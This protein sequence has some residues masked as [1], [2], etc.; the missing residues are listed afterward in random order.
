MKAR[1][2]F[3][4]VAAGAVLPAWG[5]AQESRVRRIGFLGVLS[6]STPS[7][8]DVYYDA[9]VQGMRELGY[10]E[11]K[12]LAIEWRFAEGKFDRLPALAAELAGLKVEVIVT[13]STPAIRALQRAT[14]SIPVVFAVAIDPVASGFAASLAR[15]GGNIT[16]LSVIDVD[17]SP[18]RLELLKTMNPALSRAAVLVNPSVPAHAA[19]VKSMQAAG[20][21]AGINVVPV[22]A[23][24]A[25]EIEQ[26]FAVMLR[27]R[28]GGAVVS[29]DAFFRGQRR[30]IAALALRGRIPAIA[31]WREYVTAGGLMSYGQD[32]ADS[33]RRTA[34]YVDKILK[35]ARPGELAIEQPTRIHLA[36][37]RKTAGALGL[38]IPRELLLRADEAID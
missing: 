30:Q 20:Q 12:N 15:P 23:R 13:H 10:T 9:F 36:V 32:I 29:D 27:D 25:E 14:S 21:H 18:K 33:F 17:P 8:P 31:P 28:A 26:G 6:R 1:R 5:L 34:L 37:N 35:G 19:I 16:G 24:T 2:R 22:A 7:Q 38:A 3:L 4:I 11:G